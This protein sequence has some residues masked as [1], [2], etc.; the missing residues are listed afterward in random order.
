MTDFQPEE[1]PNIFSNQ[2]AIVLPPKQSSKRK[3]TTKRKQQLKTKLIKY[4]IALVILLGASGYGL[5]KVNEWFNYHTFKF[6]TPIILQSPLLIE[7]REVQEVSSGSSIVT[8]AQ[9][10]EIDFTGATF[11]TK[12]DDEPNKTIGVSS[13]DTVVR[14]VYQLESS[15]GKNDGCRKQGLYNGYGY[16]QSKHTW[17]CFSSHEEVTQKVKAWFEKRVPVMGLSTSLCYYQSGYKTQDCEYYQKFLKI[18]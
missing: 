15:G 7:S 8:E 5:Y 12:A 2:K 18:K 1:E 11:I 10:K 13:I 17:N 14:K 4:T 16:A 9:A 6:Q 3:L